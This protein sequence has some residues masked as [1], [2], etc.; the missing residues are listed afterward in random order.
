MDHF[1]EFIQVKIM[2]HVLQTLDKSRSWVIFADFG[3]VKV[4]G[5]FWRLWAGQN[6]D[7]TPLVKSVCL[8]KYFQK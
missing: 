3:L 6:F 1:A 7:K 5:Y 8:D 2:S 4:I